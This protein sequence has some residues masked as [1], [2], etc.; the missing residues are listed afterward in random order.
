[1][2]LDPKHIQAIQEEIGDRLRFYLAGHSD[3][4]PTALC[5]LLALM[6]KAESR[7]ARES[8]TGCA[9]RTTSDAPMFFRG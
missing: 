8:K 3:D 6:E 4:V 2:K 1:M 7:H 9:V 5:R